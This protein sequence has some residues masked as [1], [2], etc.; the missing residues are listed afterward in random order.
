M[1]ESH[2][3]EEVLGKDYDAR[4]MR[5]LL[6][7]LWP[8]KW[9]ALT[10]LVLTILSAPL[11]LAGPPLTKAAIDLFLDPSR[12][13]DKSQVTGFAHTIVVWADGLGYNTARWF[14]EGASPYEGI[15]FIAILFLFANLAAFAVQY[16]QAIVM[17]AM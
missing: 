11:V 15:T 12:P 1:A 4:L 5:R 10:S 3:E 13:S 14:V 8:Y 2:H 17:Q 9:H 7:Y 16:I 6:R